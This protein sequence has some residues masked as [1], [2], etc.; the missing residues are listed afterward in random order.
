M[1]PDQ[2]TPQTDTSSPQ[3]SAP[4]Q[5]QLPNV[6]PEVHDYAHP[7]VDPPKKTYHPK[8]LLVILVAVVVLSLIAVATMLAV[9]L[10]PANKSTKNTSTGTPSKSVEQTPKTA[11][12]VIEHVRVYF[13]GKE[14]AT[15]SINLPINAPNET[16]YTVIPDTKPLVSIAG[17]ITPDKSDAQLSSITKAMDY[18]EFTKRVE[19]DGA[20]NT[21]YLANYQRSD[22]IC[23]V[24]VTKPADTK[25]P[26]WFEV[27]CLDMSQYS[28]YAKTQEQFA[29]LY[30][31]ASAGSA[32]VGFVGKPVVKNSK[33]A[34]YHTLELPASTVI[35]QKFTAIGNLAMFYQTP[36][37]LW[38][39]FQDRSNS[40]LVECEKYNTENLRFAYADQPCRRASTGKTDTVIAPK[41]KTT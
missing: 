10:M 19:T 26:H 30:T 6:Q 20:N 33:T 8:R 2:K 21:D 36:D 28:E 35:D 22:V 3:G 40:L 29:S 1:N 15:T 37:K 23:Q 41:Q 18:E 34:G 16:F 9:A 13:K 7:I 25:K 4:Q 17:P 27:R 38:R 39:Y 31:P 12:E 24:G 5:T 11:A 32:L 14:K